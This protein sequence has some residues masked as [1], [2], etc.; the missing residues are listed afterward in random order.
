MSEKRFNIF[1]FVSV[2]VLVSIAINW[3]NL[4]WFFSLRYLTYAFEEDKPV[5]QAEKTYNVENSIEIAKIGITAPIITPTGL[6]TTFK[7]ELNLGTVLYPDSVLPGENGQTTILGHSAPANWPKIKYDWV[8]NDLSK[9]VP[10]DEIVIYFNG[11]RYVYSVVK[12]YIINRGDEL[13]ADTS[14]KNTLMLMSCWPPGK[15]YKRIAVEA[16]LLTK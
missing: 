7:S 6:D 3:S 16:S 5:I 13:S 11:K 9:L 15:D 10:G 2:F 1:F 12:N 14:L 4:S 8:F